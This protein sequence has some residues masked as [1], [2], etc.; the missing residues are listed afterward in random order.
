[1][2]EARK[3]EW[4]D[5]LSVGVDSF[6]AHHRELVSRLNALVDAVERGR[7]KEEVARLLGFLDTYVK[8]HFGAEE[9]LLR[10]GGYPGLTEHAAQ[11]AVFKRTL[12]ELAEKFS[13]FGATESLLEL[14]Q[15]QLCGW[16][17]THIRLDDHKYGKFLAE[18]GHVAKGK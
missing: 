1:M 2:F 12:A 13:V 17:L 15:S 6:D 18:A 11:H 5:D 3:L 10:D 9:A 16:I 8:M 14:L 7:G 4:T